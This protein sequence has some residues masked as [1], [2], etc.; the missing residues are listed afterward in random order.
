MMPA[1]HVPMVLCLCGCADLPGVR[2]ACQF[3]EPGDG[4]TLDCSPPEDVRPEIA[5]S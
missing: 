4:Y 2:P 5:G 3:W 1:G